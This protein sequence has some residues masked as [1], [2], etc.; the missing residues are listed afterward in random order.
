MIDARSQVDIQF[1]AIYEKASRHAHSYGIEAKAP[2]RCARQTRRENHP[3][4]TEEYYRRC[5]AI[6]FLDHLKNEIDH[7]F[8]SHTVTAMRCLGIVPSC[9]ESEN[10]ASDQ[11]ML[12]FFLKMI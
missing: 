3:G 6:P 9:F 11:E 1:A 8:N 10:K 7:R 5:L 12:D 2:R 4:S